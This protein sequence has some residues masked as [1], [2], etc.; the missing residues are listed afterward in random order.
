M[1]QKYR[2]VDI[3]ESVDSIS[4]SGVSRGVLRVLRVLRHPPKA[5][6]CNYIMPKPVSLGSDC[7]IYK[8]LLGYNSYM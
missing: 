5:K 8:L 3:I 2:L 4:S 7:F 6:E 1:I